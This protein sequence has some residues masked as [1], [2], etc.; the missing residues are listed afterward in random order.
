MT[1][2]TASLSWGKL[3]ATS[4]NAAKIWL[5]FIAGVWM[6]ATQG[7]EQVEDVYQAAMAT[8]DAMEGKTYSDPTDG[9]VQRVYEAFKALASAL[10]ALDHNPVNVTCKLDNEHGKK[11]RLG[12]DG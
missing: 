10:T 6:N 1:T 5:R 4:L 9:E 3:T 11:L 2:I 7:S 12:W 8:V